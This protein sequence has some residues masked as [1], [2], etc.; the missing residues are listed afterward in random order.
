MNRILFLI[1]LLILFFY[2][3]SFSHAENKN[4][5]NTNIKTNQATFDYSKIS[6]FYGVW[7][8]TNAEKYRGGL[9]TDHLAKS[10]I[11]KR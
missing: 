11:K 1:L 5:I 10:Y 8:V 7:F 9:T 2:N 6:N 4:N 3:L